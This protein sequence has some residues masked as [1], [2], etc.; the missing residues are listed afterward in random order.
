MDGHRGTQR[1]GTAI[2]QVVQQSYPKKLPDFSLIKAQIAPP[3]GG[4]KDPFNCVA[5]TEQSTQQ[6]HADEQVQ[7]TAQ[8]LGVG[9]VLRQHQLRSLPGGQI[10]RSPGIRR[11]LV[12]LEQT[13]Q[14]AQQQ[15]QCTDD[16]RVSVVGKGA[17]HKQ[18]L[19]F[20]GT[21]SAGRN[22]SAR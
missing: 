21:I 5:P 1:L 3:A 6:R 9:A 18:F 22:A 13:V 8:N 12:Q 16:Q 10:G 15:P 11:G 14:S 19:N 17:L 20:F 7:Q 2:Q 4:G